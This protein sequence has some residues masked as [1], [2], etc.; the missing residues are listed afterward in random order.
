MNVSK[1]TSYSELLYHVDLKTL[2]HRRYPHA[3]TL[4]FT[5]ACTIRGRL[6]LRKYSNFVIINM[7]SEALTGY[8]SLPIT[9]D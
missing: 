1:L 9:T 6:V 5:N 8:I 2:E 4:F 3:P 7:T